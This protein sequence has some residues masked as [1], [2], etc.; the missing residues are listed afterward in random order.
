MWFCFKFVGESCSY[1]LGHVVSESITVGDLADCIAK[2]YYVEE[3]GRTAQLASPSGVA[4]RRTLP[5]GRAIYAGGKPLQF[6]MAY[7]E[8]LEE[9]GGAK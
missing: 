9:A 4:L 2:R 8:D 5:I 7:D 3:P 6:H 1:G